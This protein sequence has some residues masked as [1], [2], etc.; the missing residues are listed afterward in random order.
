MTPLLLARGNRVTAADI[1]MFGA[2]GLLPHVNNPLFQLEVGDIRDRRFT[3]KL[4][5]PQFD[6]V[7]HLAALVGEPACKIDPTLTRKINTDATIRLATEAKKRG[8]RR[9]VFTSTCSNYGVSSPDELADENSPLNPLSLYAETKIAAEKGLLA[10]SDS[11]FGVT[12][13]RVATLFGLSSK[14][15]FN[16]LINE[17]VRDGWHGR[18]VVLYKEDAWRPFTHTIDAA[19]VIVAVLDADK[20][21]VFGEIFNIGTDN[22]QKKTLAALV[23]KHIPSLRVKREWGQPDN[24]DYRVSFVKAK[25][26]LGFIP[27]KTIDEG[28]RELVAALGH[29]LWSDPYDAKYTD[30][31]RPDYFIERV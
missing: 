28:I 30:W 24:R 7:V 27:E 6:A 4:F 11:S 5:S 29:R 9:F 18:E 17:M 2:E 21:K 3:R 23:K 25:E 16:L 19:R 12:I 20:K 8:V 1:V 13:L 14:M 31:L 26:R 10:L 22:L 15:R